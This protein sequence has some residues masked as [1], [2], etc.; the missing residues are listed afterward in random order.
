MERSSLLSQ[1]AAGW[2]CF[3]N[4]QSLMQLVT[5]TPTVHRRW[6]SLSSHKTL[7]NLC[8]SMCTADLLEGPSCSAR[9]SLEQGS[10]N[11]L[12]PLFSRAWAPASAGGMW[13]FG[14]GIHYSLI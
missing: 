11:H 9:V 2:P 7:C 1:Q 10:T 12:S 13:S 6:K 14:G 4:A 5:V 8:G 3:V